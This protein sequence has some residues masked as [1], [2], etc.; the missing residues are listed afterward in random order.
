MNIITYEHESFTHLFNCS[1]LSVARKLY[2]TMISF[3][4]APTA[5]LALCLLLILNTSADDSNLTDPPLGQQ[6]AAG[7]NSPSFTDDAFASTVNQ[8]VL[9]QEADLPR[10]SDGLMENTK[11]LPQTDGENV[12]CAAGSPHTHKRL[13]R[14]SRRLSKRQKKDFCSF[15]HPKLAPPS[16]K[17]GASNIPARQHDKTGVGRPRESMG[18]PNEF[19]PDPM[20]D[21]KQSQLYGKPNS[22]LC[23]NPNMRVPVC[24][25][26]DQQL[27]SPAPFLVPSRFCMCIFFIYIYLYI[28]LPS[29]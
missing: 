10:L 17:P 13:S 21:F 11:S 1:R 7:F 16:S 6:A 5:L 24:T 8:P 25:P 22:A 9:Q 26:Y 14:S 2:S 27:K 28:S 20:L 23:P 12:N 29:L 15:Q 4:I 19:I 18:G 3:S